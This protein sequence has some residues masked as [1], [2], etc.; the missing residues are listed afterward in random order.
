MREWWIPEVEKRTNGRVKIELFE[1]G[2]LGGSGA[3]WDMLLSNSVDIA[4]LSI[5]RLT[6]EF[7][8][9]QFLSIPFLSDSAITMQPVFHALWAKGA[10]PEWDVVHPIC[11]PVISIYHL[12][13]ADKK[14]TTLDDLKGLKVRVS[15]ALTTDSTKA[16][17]MV[18]AYV[19]STELYL[20]LQ[21]GTFDSA[22]VLPYFR[23]TYK[24]VEVC[25]YFNLD[26]SVHLHYNNREKF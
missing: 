4:H 17:G 6:G 2:V 21:R 16:L 25:K 19:S 9:T 10:M 23:D 26:I 8:L 18:P 5:P 3:Q 24:L 1:S 11:L 12:A 22:M 20:A 15:G 13:L 7:P 14:V